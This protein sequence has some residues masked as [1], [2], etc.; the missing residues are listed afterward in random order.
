[1]FSRV[2]RGCVCWS[3]VESGTSRRC[4]PVRAIPPTRLEYRVK[5]SVSL[6]PTVGSRSNFFHE[7]P[8]A[9]LDGVAWKRYDMPMTSGRGHS[10]DKTRVPGQKVYIY[11]SDRLIPLKFVS[12]VSGGCFL[13]SSV[14]SGTTH[15]CR[16]VGAIPPT[17]LEYRVKT[18][19]SR[20]PTVASRS[21][22]FTSFRRLFS[23]E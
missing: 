3:S 10:T 6:V 14:E 8:K 18:S 19:V 7:F 12:R 9:F 15:R 22:V 20:D 2:S 4:R 21:N 11:R 5:R 23:M 17:E 1:M 13:W 16:L